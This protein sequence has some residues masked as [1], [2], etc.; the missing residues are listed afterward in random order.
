MPL[1]ISGTQK[2][3]RSLL[4]ARSWHKCERFEIV[5]I[6]CPFMASGIEE[7]DVDS[8]GSSLKGPRTIRPPNL[9]SPNLPTPKKPTP[10]YEPDLGSRPRRPVNPADN[11]RKP[12]ELPFPTHPDET[13]FI[14]PKTRRDL[15]T[16]PLKPMRDLEFNMTRN[17]VISLSGGHQHDPIPQ[18][19]FLPDG[20]PISPNDLLA[21]DQRPFNIDDPDNEEDN[22]LTPNLGEERV[23]SKS[24]QFNKL[25]RNKP[26]IW[27]PG[28]DDQLQRTSRLGN[29][30]PSDSSLQNYVQAA[31]SA[32]EQYAPAYARASLKSRPA[33]SRTVLD[34]P[35]LTSKQIAGGA[36]AAAIGAAAII[37]FKGGGSG[38]GFGGM[39]FPSAFNPRTG[40][41]PVMR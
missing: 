37:A 11:P 16:T 30:Q 7:P 26:H 12:E 25:F 21:R 33:G 35:S 18:R 14:R 31:A 23:R 15:D 41:Q 17:E 2:A 40:L 5:G 36:A 8:M 1:S 10:A 13:E 24:R 3:R 4:L 28:L 39:H 34:T 20:I 9:P 6:P 29:R 22:R 27:T 19:M 38:G 32:E